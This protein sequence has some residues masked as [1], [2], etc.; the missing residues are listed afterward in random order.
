MEKYRPTTLVVALGLVFAITDHD[1]TCFKKKV[2][3]SEQANMAH[4][5][6][7]VHFDKLIG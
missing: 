2:R 5:S 6:R 1:W 3:V 7:S 4:L